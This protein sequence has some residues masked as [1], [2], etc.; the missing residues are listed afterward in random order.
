MSKEMEFEINPELDLVLERITDLKPEFIWKAWTDPDILKE[1]FCPRPWKATECAIDLRP[2]GAF[3]AAMEGPNGEVVSGPPG[4]Y[5]EIVENRKLVWTNALLP[6]YRPVP[7]KEKDDATKDCH[8]LIFTA[9]ILIEPFEQGSKYTVIAIHRNPEGRKTHEDM[10][11]HSGWGTAFDQLVE[12]A[13]RM[14]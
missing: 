7:T 14:T 12:Y 4:C 8:D 11:F 13:G 3:S 1:W 10:G 9:V 2:G 5:L 6:G